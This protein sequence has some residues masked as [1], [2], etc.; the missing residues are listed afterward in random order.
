MATMSQSKRPKSA[1]NDA[2]DDD[3]DDVER[4]YG[5]GPL[6]LEELDEK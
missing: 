3:D 1:G 5:S 6:S 2:K 4:E